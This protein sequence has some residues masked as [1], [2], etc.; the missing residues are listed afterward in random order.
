M[1]TLA[2]VLQK[3]DEGK[4]DVTDMNT[5]YLTQT[6][7][8]LAAYLCLSPAVSDPSS[9]IRTSLPCALCMPANG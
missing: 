3:V 6:I 2:S 7:D 9:E 1:L 5:Y 8:F 4:A